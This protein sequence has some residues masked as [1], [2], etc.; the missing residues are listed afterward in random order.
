MGRSPIFWCLQ[1]SGRTTAP[2]DISD[3]TAEDALISSW[4]YQDWTHIVARLLARALRDP[5]FRDS[6][7]TDPAAA[8]AAQRVPPNLRAA[9]VSRNVRRLCGVIYGQSAGASVPADSAEGVGSP[10]SGPAYHIYVLGLGIRSHLQITRE[11]EDA[12]RA[13]R[14]VFVLHTE[15]YVVDHIRSLGVTIEELGYPYGEGEA[16]AAVYRQVADL[17][18]ESAERDP[19]VGFAVYGHPS[20]LVRPASLVRAGANGRRLRIKVIPGVS[21]LDCLIVD[22]GLDPGDRGLLMYEANY[23]LLHRPT[24]DP[25]V[26]CLLWQA[27]VV[28]TWLHTSRSSCRHRF[29]GL[30]EYLL[31]FYGPR[32]RVALATTAT[33]PLVDADIIWLPLE[34]LA[35]GYSLFTGLTTL[36]LPAVRDRPVA[37]RQ[38]L[39]NLGDPTHLRTI[40]AS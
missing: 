38:M 17:I 22:L 14:K 28:G 5:A 6:L 31:R 20:M 26:P 23:A 35:D 39:A 9:L 7:E 25:A 13:C 30:Q 1:V 24:L 33:N 12:L 15:E 27:G 8:L 40:T 4:L 3:H 19:P 18:L 34:E 10:R 16:R 2:R 11:A 32:H 37:D 29:T 21:A 36:F